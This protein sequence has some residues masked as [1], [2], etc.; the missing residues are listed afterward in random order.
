MKMFFFLLLALS[1]PAVADLE[2]RNFENAEKTKSFKG[3]LVGYNPLTK[4]VTV[5]RQSTLRPVT[6]RINLLSEEHR[7]FVESRAVEL[8]AAGG[9]RMMFYE[10]VQKF[11]CILDLHA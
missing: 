2:W 7:R 3:R 5:Q 6:F 9:L 8:E 4:K 10:N 1:S 11:F